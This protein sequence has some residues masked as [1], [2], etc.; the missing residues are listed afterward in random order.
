M[1]TFEEAKARKAGTVRKVVFVIDADWAARV[2]EVE[3]KAT[4]LFSGAS[5]DVIEAATAELD[6]LREEMPE[7]TMTFTF[8]GISRDRYDRLIRAHQPTDKQKAEAKAEGNT[9]AWNDDTFPAALIAAC[10][11]T[12]KM[13]VEDV[14]ALY[15]DDAWNVADL[16]AML[17]AA[18]DATN[19]RPVIKP[20]R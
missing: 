11:D 5:S 13:T 18:H 1:L 9:P 14:K 20:G 6:Q 16:A 10:S 7:K 4:S 17:R 15:E 8:R 19:T 3:E 12:P 2:A